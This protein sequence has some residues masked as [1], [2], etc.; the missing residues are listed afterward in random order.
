MGSI[1]GDLEI[2]VS[3]SR[4]EDAVSGSHIPTGSS[5]ELYAF[6]LIIESGEACPV[7]R[8]GGSVE[9]LEE[10]NARSCLEG[11]DGA[12]VGR[13]RFALHV[14]VGGNAYIIPRVN[15]QAG[16]GIGV[17]RQDD[18]L[19]PLGGRRFLVLQFPSG[20]IVMTLP[21]NECGRF[22]DLG[23]RKAGGLRTIRDRINLH[24]IDMQIVIAVRYG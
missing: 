11:E 2:Q 10:G 21:G 22:G 8:N 3:V 16:E 14:A 13:L 6:L 1:A 9:T 7:R 15:L 23:S 12:I 17:V 20:V 19:A 5:H 4:R 24:I 18:I